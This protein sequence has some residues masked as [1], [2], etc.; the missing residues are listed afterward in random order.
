MLKDNLDKFGSAGKINTVLPNKV[1]IEFLP[2][3]YC[4]QRTPGKVGLNTILK[5]GM[6]LKINSE[7][8]TFAYDLAPCPLPWKCNMT[9][10]QSLTCQLLTKKV[11]L[12]LLHVAYLNSFVFITSWH[13]NKRTETTLLTFAERKIFFNAEVLC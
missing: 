8:P 2:R 7:M 13:L 12:F 11:N 6:W 1:K 5:D 3:H 10:W 9:H 4:L